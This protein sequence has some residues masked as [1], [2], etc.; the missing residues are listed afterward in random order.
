MIHRLESIYRQFFWW[1]LPKFFISDILQ[2]FIVSK[3]FDIR[4]IVDISR[5]FYPW[6]GGGVWFTNSG[7]NITSSAVAVVTVGDGRWCVRG[8]GRN[9]YEKRGKVGKKERKKKWGRREIFRSFFFFKWIVEMQFLNGWIGFD[10]KM[11]INKKVKQIGP[12]QKPI[13]SKNK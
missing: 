2:L 10:T 4:Y 9:R 11:D 7:T 13:S 3:P 12:K 1:Y 8:W 5:Y 6:A